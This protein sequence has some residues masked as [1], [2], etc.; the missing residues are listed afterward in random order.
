M[1]DQGSEKRTF[2]SEPLKSGQIRRSRKGAERMK[3]G[4]RRLGNESL[5]VQSCNNF[6]F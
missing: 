4:D 3:T 6:S 2:F 1:K 5:K